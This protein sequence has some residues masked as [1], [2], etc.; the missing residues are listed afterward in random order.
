MAKAVKLLTTGQVE[1]VELP[2]SGSLLNWLYNQIGCTCIENVY[3]RGLK[4]PYL[5]VVD[6]EFLVKGVPY[7][8]F[9]GSW[10]YETHKHGQPICGTVMWYFS[11]PSVSTA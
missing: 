2:G 6:G 5:M 9:V 8:N 3:P 7:I 11:V 4:S 1:L 10:L